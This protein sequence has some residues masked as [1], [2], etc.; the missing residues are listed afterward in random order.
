MLGVT[1]GY[2]GSVMQMH[3]HRI[4]VRDVQCSGEIGTVGSHPTRPVLSLFATTP[5]SRSLTGGSWSA[6]GREAFVPSGNGLEVRRA[7]GLFFGLSHH[8]TRFDAAI[9]LVPARANACSSA[10][11][12]QASA[13]LLPNKSDASEASDLD[14]GLT[15]MC[16]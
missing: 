6:P 5:A 12:F 10:Y 4:C 3:L 15:Q 7:T 14:A 9:A 11:A 16:L 8:H 2:F 13:K 1:I